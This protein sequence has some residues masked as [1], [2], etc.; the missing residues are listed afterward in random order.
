LEDASKLYADYYSIFCKGLEYSGFGVFW[1]GRVLEKSPV[2]IEGRLY[3][4][5]D[6]P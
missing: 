6:S 1:R 4:P 5:R 2:D 3:N